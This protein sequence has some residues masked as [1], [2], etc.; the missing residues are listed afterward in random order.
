MSVVE[1]PAKHDQNASFEQRLAK[2]ADQRTQR[3]DEGRADWSQWPAYEAADLGLQNYWYPVQWAAEVKRSP[4][5]ITVC[6]ENLM[7]QRDEH[8]AVFALH[9]R[10]V[11]RG[12]KLS[13]GKEE[14]PGTVTCPYHA[15]TYRLSD[16]EMV[17]AITDGPDSPMCGQ[18]RVRTYPTAVR[19]SSDRRTAAP[20]V[21]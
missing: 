12:V 17:A 16:G 8:G 3:S 21:D 18:A 4:V 15:W 14:F 9:D 2:L 7:L 19:A 5:A 1:E 20:G 13:E 6:G 11:H 10:C